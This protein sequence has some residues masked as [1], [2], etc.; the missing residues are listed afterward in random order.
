[1]FNRI[2]S[3]PTPMKPEMAEQVCKQLIECDEDGL[4][5]EV[6]EYQGGR[7]VIIIIDGDDESF[8]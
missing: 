4:H 1:M 5:Y 2:N 3:Q 7:A 8:F 6:R